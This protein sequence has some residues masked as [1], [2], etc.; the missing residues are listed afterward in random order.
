MFDLGQPQY[1]CLFVAGGYTLLL[2]CGCGGGGGGWSGCWYWILGAV[3]G[4]KVAT[5]ETM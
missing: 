5:A 4:I 1:L 3:M 2:L